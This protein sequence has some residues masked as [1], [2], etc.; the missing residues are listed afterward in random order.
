M[1]PQQQ[2]RRLDT[3]GSLETLDVKDSYP[4]SVFNTGLLSD[5]RQPAGRG[6]L[7]SPESV[8]NV[9]VSDP[10]SPAGVDRSAGPGGVGRS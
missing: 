9:V 4:R 7:S 1:K 2:Q 5:T 8:Y 3:G 6:Y 10:A